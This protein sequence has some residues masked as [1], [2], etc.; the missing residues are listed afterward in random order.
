MVTGKEV[1]K[2]LFVSL[3]V[4]SGCEKEKMNLEKAIGLSEHR[5]VLG[6]RADSVQIQV[7][8]DKCWFYGVREIHRGD[9]IYHVY[10]DGN[11]EKRFQGDWFEAKY[12]GDMIN[13]SIM[14][15]VSAYPR[16]L[17]FTIEWMDYFDYIE[18]FQEGNEEL[19]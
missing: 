6:E 15:N 7:H 13:I 11:N 19:R 17:L 18:V 5:V 12:V 1:C 16:E 4:L 14:K 3:L 9:T 10:D 8:N 2:L